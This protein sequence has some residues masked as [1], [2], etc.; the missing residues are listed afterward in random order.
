MIKLTIFG[1]GATV[2]GGIWTFED[3]RDRGDVNAAL[4]LHFDPFH[5]HP[6]VDRAQ[7]DAVIAT[8][9]GQVEILKADEPK[10]QSGAIY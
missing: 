3:D 7:V 2:A 8:W 10:E 5:Y 6:D 9:P 4:A 1:R